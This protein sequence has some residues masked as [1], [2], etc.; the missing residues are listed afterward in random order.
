VKSATVRRLVGWMLA[1][2]C[3]GFVLWRAAQHADEIRATPY[4]P[5]GW[6]L[7]AVLSVMLGHFLAGNATFLALRAF[8]AQP[9]W[10][11]AIR[12]HLL[13]QIIKYLPVGGV[14]NVAAQ[15]HG[16]ARLPGVTVA[17]SVGAI[18][19][20]L[21]IVIAA[22]ATWFGL[23]ALVGA[24][25]DPAIAVLCLLGLPVLLAALSSRP[26]R[27]TVVGWL[28]RR[29]ATHEAVRSAGLLSPRTALTFAIC[30]L[31]AAAAYGFSLTLLALPFATLT[32]LSAVEIAGMMTA[33]WALGLMSFIVPAGLGVRETALM[34]MLQMVL[35]PPAPAVLPLVARIVWLL[36][37][38]LNFAWA[39]LLL[40][41]ATLPPASDNTPTE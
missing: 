5:N 13:A 6:T 10:I 24:T 22:G 34:L 39:G 1:V 3:L 14:L 4:R 23:T 33:S 28:P 11:G 18:P 12:V 16:Y 20:A 19:F 38:V 7:L 29:I 8:H 41:G 40:R 26:L 35:P 32:G 30:G 25:I 31:G 36:A 17:Q 37:D 9:H 21:L 2:G 15:A 27:A